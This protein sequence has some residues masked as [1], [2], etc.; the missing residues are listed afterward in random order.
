MW[1][2]GLGYWNRFYEGNIDHYDCCGAGG[3]P[4]EPVAARPRLLWVYHICHISTKDVLF[5]VVPLLEVLINE[6]I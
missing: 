2:L 5:P 3:L 1:L 4:A 6:F